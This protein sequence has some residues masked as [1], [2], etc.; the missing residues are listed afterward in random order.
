[1]LIDDIYKTY[2]FTSP[3]C[4]TINDD[5]SICTACLELAKSLRR[6]CARRAKNMDKAYI[7]GHSLDLLLAHQHLL[8]NL[9]R[10]KQEKNKIQSIGR[11]YK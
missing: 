4:S 9:L 11:H 7:L 3:L 10:M 8:G 5:G 2:S 6:K 1:M